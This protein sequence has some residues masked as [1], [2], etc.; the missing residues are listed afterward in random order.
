MLLLLLFVFCMHQLI[1]GEKL[2]TIDFIGFL[3]M[4]FFIFL[5][6]RKLTN[7]SLAVALTHWIGT[8]AAKLLTKTYFSGGWLPDLVPSVFL[9]I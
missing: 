4:I 2:F 9:L 3:K 6:L 8:D 5:L 7:L 1:S